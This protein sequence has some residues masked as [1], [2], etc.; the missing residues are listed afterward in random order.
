MAESPV[1]MRVYIGGFAQAVTADDVSGRFKPFGQVHAVDLPTVRDSGATR[2]FGYVSISITPSQ[3]QRC[4]RVYGGA[5][6]KGGKLRVEE[7][8]EDYLAKLRREMAEAS[9]PKPQQPAG[10]RGRRT[11]SDGV[12]AEDMEL[13]TAKNVGR[14]AGWTKNRY[15]RPVLKY[16][17]IK[18]NG[19][20]FT[21][22]PIR[23]GK[24]YA[25]H[26]GAIT[27][28]HSSDLQ[29]EYDAERARE[30][31]ALAKRLPDN[32]VALMKE[33]ERRLSKRR[34]IEEDSRKAKERLLAQSVKAPV[35]K[36]TTAMSDSTNVGD[37]KDNNSKDSV[38]KDG[39]SKDGRGKGDGGFESDADSDIPD[40]ESLERSAGTG[41]GYA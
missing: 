19:R 31:F 28:K 30:D 33:T 41:A 3:W 25:R 4:A 23:S 12:M 11:G 17:I 1:E 27:S 35:S 36:P 22:D 29:W 16:S 6:W 37:S 34:K 32:T 13:V 40:L 8:R 7:A 26:N 20:R 14:Y 2:G 5:T 38:S 18:P 15:G 39:A 9:D 21:Y 24:N 10:K